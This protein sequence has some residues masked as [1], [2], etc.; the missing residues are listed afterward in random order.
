MELN[1]S[2]SL[3]RRPATVRLFP[4]QRGWR[5]GWL[6]PRG[7]DRRGSERREPGAVEVPGH[8]RP[9]AFIGRWR[10]CRELMRRGRG[11]RCRGGRAPPA[12]PA[13]FTSHVAFDRRDPAALADATAAGFRPGRGCFDLAVVPAI[14]RGRPSSGAFARRAVRAWCP[15]NVYHDLPRPPGARGG[16]HSLGRSGAGT[17]PQGAPPEGKRW[18]ENGSSRERDGLPVGGV[19]RPPAVLGPEG[20]D[21]G[22]SPAY[23]QRVA[24]G[25]PAPGARGVRYRAGRAGLAWGSRRGLRLRGWPCDTRAGRERGRYNV[26]VFERGKRPRPAGGRGVAPWQAGGAGPGPLRGAAGGSKPVRPRAPRRSRRLL[27]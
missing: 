25:R 18:C 3:H 20:P 13:R 8:R 23:L 9:P 17:R 1:P 19:V 11:D 5:N 4:G 16:L 15:A 14:G 12:L 26:R 2:H 7:V 24:D 21:A 6:A 22:A 10:A 27:T